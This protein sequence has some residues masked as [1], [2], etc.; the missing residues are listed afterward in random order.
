MNVII[1]EDEH[2]MA[3]ALREEI[4]QADP[5]I[6]IVA[7]LT[8]IKEAIEY[9]GKNDFPDL[10]FSDIE[11]SDGL[12]F[13]IFK[14]T[15]NTVPIIFCTAYNHY[16]LEAFQVYG[17]DYLLK[18]FDSND[19]HAALTKYKSLMTARL[20]SNIDYNAIVQ[21]LDSRKLE[22]QNSV[23]IYRG[24]K[25][26][27]LPSREVAVAAL[28]KGVVYVYTFNNKRYSVNYN[29]ERLHH[30]LGENFYRVNR[31]YIISRKAVDQVSQY[32]ARKLLVHLNFDFKAELVVSKANASDFLR[33]LETY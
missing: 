10:F 3:E 2:L 5:S 4:S 28:E 11:L 7:Q 17:V 27:P 12:S 14:R 31:Q 24:D 29:M 16:A 21:L 6:M 26:V 15:N 19:I 33:W 9:L 13:E 8:S 18:P 1:I 32:F 23:L 20:E 25:I 22:K 30:L